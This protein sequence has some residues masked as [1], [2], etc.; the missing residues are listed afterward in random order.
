MRG[1]G[2]FITNKI[3]EGVK[4]SFF[5]YTK[6][7]IA[8]TCI[9][10]VRNKIQIE[11]FRLEEIYGYISLSIKLFRWDSICTRYSSVFTHFKHPTVAQLRLIVRSGG[12]CAEHPWGE[13]CRPHGHKIEMIRSTELE[14]YL[15]FP[16]KTCNLW[17][18]IGPR[19]LWTRQFYIPLPVIGAMQ[20][21]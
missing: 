9:S 18:V 10:E 19:T 1:I 6:Y 21:Q 5:M 8:Y 13:G 7:C 3:Y 4:F 2:I 14:N 16:R 20:V 17:I 11:V 15:K 12:S